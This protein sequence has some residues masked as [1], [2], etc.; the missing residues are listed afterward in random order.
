MIDF[1]QRYC[2]V[3]VSELEITDPKIMLELKLSLDAETPDNG[4]VSLYNLSKER[5]QQI[6]D[7]GDTIVVDAG[8]LNHHGEIF[9]G[10]VQRVER[11]REDL[12]RITRIA[13]STQV[14]SAEMVNGTTMRAIALGTEV[15]LRQIVRDLI[16]ADLMMVVGNIETVPDENLN[17]FHWYGSTWKGLTK[18]LADFK[19]QPYIDG[20]VVNFSMVGETPTATNGSI[21]TLSPETGL[22][23]APTVTNEGARCRSLLNHA[24]KLNTQVN[25]KSETLTKQLK[26]VGMT[27]NGSN[28]DGDWTTELDLRDPALQDDSSTDAFAVVDTGGSGAGSVA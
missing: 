14:P 15:A 18:T 12:A 1:F 13:V 28:W 20:D 11:A 3:A 10:R 17:G 7:R 5:E 2:K 9:N 25:L 4:S 16:E 26:I 24:F 19:V 21:L 23:G 22:L 6:I 8:Y 27:Y